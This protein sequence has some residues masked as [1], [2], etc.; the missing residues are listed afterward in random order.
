MRL[1]SVCHLALYFKAIKQFYY[2]NSGTILLFL[3][4]RFIIHLDT[5]A[6]T[7]LQTLWLAVH[8]HIKV[9]TL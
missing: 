8:A 7:K 5:S 9:Y 1:V 2:Y 6:V 3:R 4:F